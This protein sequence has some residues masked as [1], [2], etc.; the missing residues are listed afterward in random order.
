M[1]G[2]LIEGNVRRGIRLVGIEQRG[3]YTNIR[4]NHAKRIVQ[5]ARLGHKVQQAQ[6]VKGV[7]RVDSGAV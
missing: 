7:G 4:E 5:K 3:K 1:W 6:T 2:C